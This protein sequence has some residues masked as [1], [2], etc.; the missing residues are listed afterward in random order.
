MLDTHARK[1]VQPIIKLVAKLFIKFGFTANQVTFIAFILGIIAALTYLAGFTIPALIILWISGL[2]D[3]VDGTIARETQ[4]SS[5]FG[6]VMDVT[7]DRVV[8]IALMIVLALKYPNSHFA[9]MILA[10]SII[11]NMTVFLTVGAAAKNETVKS[12]HYQTGVA[13]RTEGF[14]FFSLMM[15]FTKHIIL[16]AVLFTLVVLFTSGQRF[17]EA[18]QILK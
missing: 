9:L 1:Y 2:L 6:T 12:F 4:S 3:A 15:I 5:P 18:S 7:L 14:I 17:R 10:C 16:V 8:E 11:I 13:E